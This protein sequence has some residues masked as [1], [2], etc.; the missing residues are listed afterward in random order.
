MLSQILPLSIA[1]YRTF[2]H[3]HVAPAV[4]I[5]V[6]IIY[7]SNGL[8]N[9]LLF[10]ITRPF[11]LPH[12]LPS[13]ENELPVTAPSRSEGLDDSADVEI[14]AVR[15]ESPVNQHWHGPE[16]DSVGGGT[17]RWTPDGVA[18]YITN[19]QSL[20]TDSVGL[21]YYSPRPMD[22]MLTPG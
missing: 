17:L 3:H 18:T 2:A 1:R 5:V 4:T 11:L 10:S 9:V 16:P 15:Y 12:D 6:D 21:Y 8:F 20:S 7:L 13:S 22:S 19:V 14:P